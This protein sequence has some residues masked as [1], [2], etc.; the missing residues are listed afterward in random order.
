[1]E[2]SGAYVLLV[3][4]VELLESKRIKK[5]LGVKREIIKLLDICSLAILF[6]K[7]FD[8]FNIN[9]LFSKYIASTQSIC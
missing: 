9:G 5:S 2:D 7:M 8:R 1:M 4:L 3:L 6:C